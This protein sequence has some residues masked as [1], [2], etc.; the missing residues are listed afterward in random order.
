MKWLHLALCCAVLVGAQACNKGTSGGPGANTDS[1]ISAVTQ[2]EGTFSLDVPMMKTSLV[3]GET[4]TIAIGIKRGDN[5]QEEVALNFS[6]L[7]QGVTVEP[8][9]IKVGEAEAM[10]KISAAPDA[11]I[12]DFTVKVTGHPGK[13]ADATNELKI[14]VSQ[15]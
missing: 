11:A 5:F 15:K 1:A 12:G 2:K 3:Q 9:S 8:A 4:K 6:D 13:G 14:S 7:P 10:V